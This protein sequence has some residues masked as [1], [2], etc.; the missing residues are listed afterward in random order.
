MCL[1]YP[2]S[3]FRLPFLYFPSQKYEEYNAYCWMTVC[4]IFDVAPSYSE[5]DTT[6]RGSK[7][8]SPSICNHSKQS[9]CGEYI[10]V[11]RKIHAFTFRYRFYMSA[12]HMQCCLLVSI[13]LLIRAFCKRRFLLRHREISLMLTADRFYGHLK[14]FRSN[15]MCRIRC[16][17]KSSIRRRL[18]ECIPIG[19]RNSNKGSVLKVSGKTSRRYCIRTKTILPYHA[20]CKCNFAK[21]PRNK[22]SARVFIFFFFIFIQITCS[23]KKSASRSEIRCQILV[24]AKF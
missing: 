19:S 24:H 15:K 18:E 23:S 11:A 21:A 14:R 3:P 16:N 5:G 8:K 6:F 2:T 1:L 17:M 13:D 9:T 10:R 4:A 7:K 22:S 20:L 12:R